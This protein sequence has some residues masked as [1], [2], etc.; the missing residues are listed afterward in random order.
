MLGKSLLIL[1][2]VVLAA[3]A[4]SASAA[5]PLSGGS[6]PQRRDHPDDRGYHPGRRSFYNYPRHRH[7]DGGVDDG[8]SFGRPLYGSIDGSPNYDGNYGSPYYGTNY[9]AGVLTVAATTMAVSLLPESIGTEPPQ[10]PAASGRNGSK[11]AAI[12]D[13]RFLSLPSWVCH[14]WLLGAPPC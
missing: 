3:I 12:S 5:I 6:A 4:G 13:S 1:S 11:K 9:G 7:I 14:D 10:N 8:G 2:A